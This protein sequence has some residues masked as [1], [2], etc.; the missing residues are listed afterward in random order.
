FGTTDTYVGV[1]KGVMLN[2]CPDLQLVDLTHAVQPQNVKQAAFLLLNSYA[3]FPPGTVF[4]VVVDPGVGGDRKPIA[5]RAGEYTFVA[6]D[7]GVLTYILR[8]LGAFQAVEL[9]NPAYRLPASN[10]FHGRDIFAPTAAHLAAG[11]PFEQFG[12]AVE[13]PVFLPLPSLIVKSQHIVGEVLHIDHFGSVA[14]SIGWLHWSDQQLVLQS[15]FGEALPLMLAPDSATAI[16]GD[17]PI[18]RI[19]RTYADV[20]S[21][22]ALALVG[23]SGYLELSVNQGS[24][25]AQFGVKIGDPVELQIG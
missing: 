23:S 17:Q 24:F 7:N 5:V 22:E 8:E 2:I 1:M 10:T 13:Q 25:A 18:D 15:R 4:L 3:Y 20:E 12:A 9:S 19:R 6:P 16:I 11:V 14:T 21:G